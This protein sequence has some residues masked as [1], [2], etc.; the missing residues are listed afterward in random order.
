MWLQKGSIG[1]I[2]VDGWSIEKGTV[3][4]ERSFREKSKWKRQEFYTN[5]VRQ[6]EHYVKE[7]DII[8]LRYLSR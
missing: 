2:E 7:I 8:R 4:M 3:K 6:K 1:S 5:S